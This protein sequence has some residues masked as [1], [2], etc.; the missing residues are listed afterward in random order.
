MTAVAPAGAAPSMPSCRIPTDRAK[1]VGQSLHPTELAELV[2]ELG[3]GGLRYPA[4]C[5]Q[6]P[7]PHGTIHECAERAPYRRRLSSA[8]SVRSQTSEPVI[9]ADEVGEE[10]VRVG[11]LCGAHPLII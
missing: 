11:V 8:G 1:M 2:N 5:R 3:H 4:E 10:S 9:H 7:Q 6:L